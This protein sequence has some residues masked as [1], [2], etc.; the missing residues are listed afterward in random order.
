[1][2]SKTFFRQPE[3]AISKQYRPVHA[4]PHQTTVFDIMWYARWGFV[5][6]LTILCIAS[7]VL[8]EFFKIPLI[9]IWLVL[10]FV[11]ILNVVFYYL[12]KKTNIHIVWLLEFAI[13]ADILALSELLVFTG[14]TNNPLIFLFLFHLVVAALVCP[15]AFSWLIATITSAIYFALFFVH[16]PLP[17]VSRYADSLLHI[18]LM[19]MWLTFLISAVLITA[20]ITYLSKSIRQHEWQLNQA[21]LKQQEHEYWLKIGMSAANIA[22]QLSTPLNSMILLSQEMQSEHA[23]TENVQNDFSLLDTQLQRCKTLLQQLKYSSE[24][25]CK[26]I[27]LNQTLKEQLSQWHNLRPDAHCT[28]HCEPNQDDVFAWLDDAFWGAFLNILNNAADAGNG[29][30]DL[31]TRFLPDKTWEIGLHN[32]QGFLSSEQ[33]RKA[34]LDIQESDKPAGLG[35]GVRLSHATLSRLSGSLTLSNH[36]EGGVFARII[37]PLITEIS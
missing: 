5:L 3:K 9:P 26:Q 7:P 28:W 29:E 24:G 8:H 14:G 21:Y 11:I 37:L 31:Y 15:K 18:H 30:V 16:L 1:M 20:S 25:G 22:H 36:E 2:V 4:L 34:G 33:L 17:L 27:W 32:R 10:F 23:L 6:M 12:R 35:L 13:L 19:G